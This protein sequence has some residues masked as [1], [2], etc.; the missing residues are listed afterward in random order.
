MRFSPYAH[1]DG[2]KLLSAVQGVDKRL[3]LAASQP[4]SLNL[5]DPSLSPEEM[6]HE[7]V[8]IMEKVMKN[9]ARN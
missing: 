3:I 9:L 8:R 1:P 5:R 4:P 6:L 7:G 2:A